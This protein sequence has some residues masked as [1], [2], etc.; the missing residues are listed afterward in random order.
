MSL[1]PKLK[2]K[3]VDAS[4]L[5]RNVSCRAA[6]PVHTNAQGYIEAISQGDFDLAY[7][8]ARTPNPFVNICARICGHPCEAACRRGAHD[9]PLSIRAL[10]RAAADYSLGAMRSGGAIP[11]RKKQNKAVAVIGAGPAGVTAAHD[12]ALYGYDVT[13]FEG[14]NQLGGMLY[15]GVPEYRLPRDLL[16]AEI[17]GLLSVGI[18][19]RMNTRIGDK[20]QFS[21]IRRDYKAVFL[22]V[23]AQKGRDL[24]IGNVN[25]DGVIN[26]IDFLLNVSLGY[27][28]PMGKRVVVIGGGNVAVDVARTAAREAGILV[29]EQ[30]KHYEP[31]MDIARSAMRMGAAEVHMVCLESYEE[32]PAHD[33]EI[34]ETLREGI[35]LHNSRGP[36]NVVVKDGKCIGLET[37]KC[38]SVFD[39]N[40]RFSPKFAENSQE[41]LDCDT[42]LLAIG[43]M[44]DLSFLGEENQLDRTP[45][46][47]VKAAGKTMETN[48]P[49]VY[50]GGDVALAHAPQSKA[51]PMREE[52]PLRFTNTYRERA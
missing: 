45:S 15:H 35:V 19:V 47:F 10:K 36:T 18:N 5:R 37:V 2:A 39:E 29:P 41:I 44:P 32:M 25:A 21:D 22:A 24:R 31:A 16:K 20:I 13:L 49:G 50:V 42:I 9:L 28:V 11:R 46:G 52:R 38:L 27:K 43:Q 3:V 8:L 17:D 26:G 33:D 48:L 23:G 34:E 40:R 30:E 1:L 6:C 14:S 12:L 7:E 51:L 4:W